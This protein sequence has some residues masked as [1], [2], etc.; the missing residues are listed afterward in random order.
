MTIVYFLCGMGRSGTHAIGSWLL[1]Q[2]R[3]F[4][5]MDDMSQEYSFSYSHYKKIKEQV[6]SGQLQMPSYDW[7][8]VDQ[9]E[10]RNYEGN[11]NW[12]PFTDQ[13]NLLIHVES[14]ELKH[15][16]EEIE[17]YRKAGVDFKTILLLRNPFNNFASQRQSNESLAESRVDLWKQIAREF[18]GYTNYLGDKVFC[19]YDL[20]FTSEEYRKNMSKKLGVE[21]DDSGLNTINRHGSSHFEGDKAGQD[22]KVLERW[23]HYYESS[24]EAADWYHLK[25]EN[26]ST[27]AEGPRSRDIV[28]TPSDEMRNE[29]FKQL[30]D[31]EVVELWKII[32]ERYKDHDIKDCLEN[33][34][35]I[36]GEYGKVAKFYKNYF[37]G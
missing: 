1:P 36:I 34:L 13:H 17:E 29:K 33:G 27:S 11:R 4:F 28:A 32:I 6:A 35:E 19:I 22:L 3:P 12:H 8:T 23:K 20:W 37:K 18:L 24:D 15:I 10:N 9:L 26:I 2:I 7:N 5:Q 14:I 25:E 31:E 21:W 16:G 30:F